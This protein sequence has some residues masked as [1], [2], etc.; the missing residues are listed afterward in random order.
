MIHAARRPAT[1]RFRSTSRRGLKAISATGAIMAVAAAA[2][3]AL[4]HAPES[5]SSTTYLG[6][7][8]EPYS[9]KID[10]TYR[11]GNRIAEGEVRKAVIQC[12]DGTSST[13]DFTFRGRVTKK[14]DFLFQR[15]INF[16]DG[17]YYLEIAARIKDKLAKGTLYFLRDSYDSTVA[18][19]CT[20]PT[21][22]LWKALR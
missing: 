1:T 11:P 18:P 17:Q 9:G 15:H 8:V 12:E 20:T 14:G 21:P 5:R 19:D 16:G 3:G 7:L 6:A 2:G 13:L 22:E 10:L 4:A